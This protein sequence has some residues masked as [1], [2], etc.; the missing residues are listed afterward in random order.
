ML[1]YYKY[2]EFSMYKAMGFV[3]KNEE[4]DNCL[5]TIWLTHITPT[6]IKTSGDIWCSVASR[7]C[8]V[9]WLLWRTIRQL[10]QTTT[11]CQKI[12]RKTID[13]W[14]ENIFCFCIYLTIAKTNSRLYTLCLRHKN[15]WSDENK[16]ERKKTH[17][18]LQV[19]IEANSIS[20]ESTKQMW[21][22]LKDVSNRVRA[23][24]LF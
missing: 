15:S 6:E 22:I 2:D 7:Q 21:F 18:T 17:N 12:D 16:N 13:W 4:N 10:R 11:M 20:A 23:H 3:A 5:Y 1:M 8:A 19:M 24:N 9:V 14:L